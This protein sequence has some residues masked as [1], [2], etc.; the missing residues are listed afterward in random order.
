MESGELAEFAA[1]WNLD[2][3]AVEYLSSLDDSVRITL[4]TEFAPRDNTHDVAGKLYAFARSIMSQQSKTSTLSPE[5]EAFAQRWALDG[6]AVSWLAGLP[7]GVSSILVEQFDPKEDTQNVIGKLRGFARSI[8]ARIPAGGAVVAEASY[9]PTFG[10]GQVG[11]FAAKW[12]LEE[13]AVTLLAKLPPQVQQT[14][15]EQFDPKG[16]TMNINGKLCAFA[17]SIAAGTGRQGQGVVESFAQHWGLDAGTAQFLKSLPE[18]VLA[19]VIQQFDPMAGTRDV[20]GRLKMFAKGIL[21]KHSVGG[22]HVPAPEPE[23]FRGVQGREFHEAAPGT[24]SLDSALA[25]GAAEAQAAAMVASDPAVADFVV[26]WSLDASCVQMLE[27]LPE[28]ARMKVLEQFD[29]RGNTRN[30]SAKLRAF[31]NTVVSGQGRGQHAAAPLAVERQ[32]APWHEPQHQPQPLHQPHHLAAAAVPDPSEE[33]AFLERWG[34]ST[35]PSALDVL[36]RLHPPVRAR[37]MREFAPAA[38][39]QD[40]FGK[41]CGF[42]SSVA[43]GAAKGGGASAMGGKGGAPGGKGFASAL[44]PLRAPSLHG[45]VA[46]QGGH[47]PGSYLNSHSAVSLPRQSAG[48]MTPEQFADKWQL[49]AGS[50]ALLSGLDPAA[51]A[52]VIIE[53]QP[54]GETRDTSGKFCAFARSV[55]TRLQAPQGQKRGLGG[56]HSLGPPAARARY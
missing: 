38:D 28:D 34:L 30:I 20:C 13:S 42:A 35:N 3:Q 49:D 10:G 53:F 29:P 23:P 40:V 47:G 12:G 39:T 45:P 26:R 9:Q 1:R 19:I 32:V 16:D 14:V 43:K 15:I 33:A 8:Q 7:P 25:A 4:L 51:Q 2:S 50:R 21:A 56:G 36:H 52:T 18:E 24:A 17:R 27:S 44:P 5:L 37:V 41:F 22:E 31:A 6:A 48:G 11:E 46:G 54:R 55:A